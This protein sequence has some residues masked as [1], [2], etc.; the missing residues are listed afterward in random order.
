[1]GANYSL[2]IVAAEIHQRQNVF[3]QIRHKNSS[4]KS[5]IERKNH[6]RERERER[7]T[8]RPAT[9]KGYPIP[10]AVLLQR[11]TDAT[12]KL[13]GMGNHLPVF[14][15]F[16]LSFADEREERIEAHTAPAATGGRAAAATAT[17]R[18]S[19][20]QVSAYQRHHS[21]LQAHPEICVILK[22]FPFKVRTILLFLRTRRRNPGSNPMEK[23]ERAK[24]HR[25][26]A[27][28][29][30]GYQKNRIAAQFCRD[31]F[32]VVLPSKVLQQQYCS[33]A[34][35]T[36]T[37]RSFCFQ[38]PHASCVFSRYGDPASRNRSVLLVRGNRLPRSDQSKRVW[39]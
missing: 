32:V 14:F 39:R 25:Y 26:Y 23:K 16:F 38:F 5:T 17:S 8:G 12:R 19:D 13:R 34:S 28:G 15:S 3:K 30:G 4:S 31:S 18:F 1:M 11:E 29:G 27:S 10:Q 33:T 7:R 37:W 6:E 24:Q 2:T 35:Y 9:R 21:L 22:K 36:R 20:L